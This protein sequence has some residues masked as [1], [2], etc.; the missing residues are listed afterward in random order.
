MRQRLLKGNHLYAG[1]GGF[2]NL[3]FANIQ[4]DV[5]YGRGAEGAD[6]KRCDA[7][8]GGEQQVAGAQVAFG[9]FA[10][11]AAGNLAL[12]LEGNSPG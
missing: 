2:R 7:Q 5:A 11:S 9:D 10:Q 8:A 3:T 1:A 4:R 6:P 12:T